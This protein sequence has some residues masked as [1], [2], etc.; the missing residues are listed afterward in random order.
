[1][2]DVTHATAILEL[3]TVALAAA[4][5]QGRFSAVEVMRTYLARAKE[6]NAACNAITKW[7]DDAEI[8]AERADEHFR[9]TGNVLGPLHG[10]PFTIKDHI[11][12][13]G[14]PVFLNLLMLKEQYGTGKHRDSRGDAPPVM[15]L[16]SLGAIPFA[17]TTMSALGDT[18]GG[19]GAAFGDTL[20]PWNT[21]RTTGGSSSGEGALIGGGASP[22][23]IGSDIGGSLRIPAAFCGICTLKPTVFRQDMAPR[24]PGEYSVCA[25]NG[26]MAKTAEDVA[27]IN[28][29]LWCDKLFDANPRLPRIPF[30]HA[31]LSATRPLRI[32]YYMEEYTQPKPCP[33]VRRAMRE[34]I[35]ALQRRGHE[36]VPFHPH[37]DKVLRLEEI[38]GIDQSFLVAGRAPLSKV[39]SNKPKSPDRVRSIC[40]PEWVSKDEPIHPDLMSNAQPAIGRERE[41]FEYVGGQG[42]TGYQRL[43]A[44]RDLLRNRFYKAWRKA[45]LDIL[46][47]PAW[48]IPAC[49]VEEVRFLSKIYETTRVYNFLDVPAG[50]VTVST[51]TAEDLQQPYEPD[52]PDPAISSAA[53]RCLE[54]AEGLPVG[55]QV[56]ALPWKEELALR[57]MREVQA[58]CP[59]DGR[60]AHLKPIP[61]RSPTLGAH[62]E[63]VEAAVP[64]AT[65]SKL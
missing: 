14:T 11:E 20:N 37:S 59:F 51:V 48:A 25:T 24:T 47:C 64:A 61:R 43:L 28:S 19:G 13:Q 34:V 30:N 46:V 10:V 60:H 5:Q 7:I 17:K 58:A 9:R 6:I 50:V 55:V 44:K 36:L 62:P 18:W 63:R 4:L 8:A 29:V 41:G 39:E 15:V 49:Q 52:D 23:G 3:S 35:E 56:V 21:L 16:K 57:G 32:G 27:F 26:I 1:M 22:F 12:A 40:F 53:L 33:T 54:G 38:R 31:E 42:P 45:G 65:I 2:V